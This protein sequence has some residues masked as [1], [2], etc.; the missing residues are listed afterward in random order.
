MSLIKEF[1]DE[2]LSGEPLTE[3]A[4]LAS[5][6]KIVKAAWAE[7]YRVGSVDGHYNEVCEETDVD[8]FL[9]RSYVET[10][11]EEDYKYPTEEQLRR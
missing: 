8:W 3:E 5:L 9:G 11:F 1:F 10:F 7:A 2:E 6:E 4:V